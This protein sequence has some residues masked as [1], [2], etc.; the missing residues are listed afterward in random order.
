MKARHACIVTVLSVLSLSAA[1]EPVRIVGSDTMAP[2]LE[3]AA[4]RYR[5]LEPEV[6][7]A[8]EGLGSSTG[9]PALLFGRAEIASM[10]RPMRRSE[11]E[12]FRRK[13]GRSPT[14]IGIAYDALIVYVNAKNPLEQISL[15]QVD[16]IFSETRECGAPRPIRKWGDLG[17]AGD[18]ADRSITLHGRSPSSGTHG[19]FRQLALCGGRFDPAV[20]RKPGA[21]SCAMSVAESRSSMG[22]GSRSDLIRGVKPLALSLD[23]SGKAVPPSE[24]EVYS[25][26]YPLVRQLL[27]YVSWRPGEPLDPDLAGFLGY[28]MSDEGQKLIEEHAHFRLKPE[29]RQA[30]SEQLAEAGTR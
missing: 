17:L 3:E 29:R 5:S 22:Y 7:I 4:E 26:H 12:A 30:W 28:L 13:Q 25:R 18:W 16:A 8:V 15:L 6:Q 10:T 1:A 21:K 14:A 11:L 23:G 9:P 20:R 24:S 27:L 2:L 19:Y